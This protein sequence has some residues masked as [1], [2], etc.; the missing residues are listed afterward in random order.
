VNNA[1]DSFTPPTSAVWVNG[2]WFLSLMIS[3]TCSLLAMLLQQWARWYLKVTCLRYGPHKRAR[4]RA[5]YA[6]GVEKPHLLWTVVMLQILLHASLF[7][8]FAG[9]S[10]FVFSV[11]LTIFKVV[12]ALVGLC[13]IVYAW[14][15]FIKNSPY[16]CTTF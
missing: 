15:T 4:V 7:L 16:F 12:I 2:L 5:F 8:F 11:N 6:E 9:L 1:A 10:I 14:L 3:L 13:V